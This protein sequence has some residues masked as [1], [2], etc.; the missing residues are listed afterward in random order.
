MS[1]SGQ[2]KEELSRQKLGARHCRIAE[3]AAILWMCGGVSVSTKDKFCLKMQTENLAVARKYF[4]LL[5]KTFNIRVELCIRQNK[6]SRRGRTYIVYVKNHEDT[7]RIL[8]AV[9][10]LG[11]D[12]TDYMEGETADLQ[13]NLVI[14]RTCCKRA[15]LRGAFLA[16]GSVSDPQ[17]FYHME[18]ACTSEYRAKQIQSVLRTFELEAR[19]ILRKK[20]YVVYLKEG[21][22][23]VDALN[24]MEA[25]MALMELENIRILKD[26][27]NTVNR[28]V[29][30]EAANIH[31]TVSAAVKQIEDIKYI[32]DTIGFD[33][34]SEALAQMAEVRL[35]NPDATLK[36]LGLLLTPSVGKSGVNHRLRKLGEIAD[37]LRD[38]K[39]EKH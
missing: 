34:L 1:F 22:Q 7:V 6:G 25:H 15:F 23:I 38:N 37:E 14:Q 13:D 8:Q 9:K 20:Y 26:M 31:K 28:K 17:R 10:L 12:G 2:I 33:D 4:T 11:T 18:F 36:E 5:K 16:A 24:V 27:R 39:E 3:T 30:C 32:R 21:N 35:S 19:I 29:N